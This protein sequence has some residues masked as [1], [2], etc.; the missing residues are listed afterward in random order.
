LFALG[1]LAAALHLRRPSAARADALAPLVVII[2]ASTGVTDISLGTLRRVFQGARTEYAAG[3][4]LVPF[5]LATGTSERVLFDRAVLG[6]EPQDVG[7]FWINARIRDE[8]LP[9]RT[10]QRI[11]LAV[12]LVTGYPGAI[13]YMRSERFAASVRVLTIN[14]VA[15][16][17]P[18]YL[19]ASK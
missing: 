12:P 10:V 14:R 15:P 13:V 7:R 9:P 5:N 3:K 19:F 17:A 6:L 8:G 4:R 18:S 11:D 1:L 2:A 16:G